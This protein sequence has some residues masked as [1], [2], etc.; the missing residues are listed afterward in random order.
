[1]ETNKLHPSFREIF[2]PRNRFALDVLNDWA[3]GFVDRDGKF[4]K[5]FQL[6]FNSSFWELY[7]FAVLKNYGCQVSLQFHRPDFVVDNPVPFC[8]EATV[9]LNDVRTKPAYEADVSDIYEDLNALN[10]EAVIRLSNRFVTKHKKYISEYSA[11]DHVSGRPFI[12]AIAPF[13]RPFF[14]MQ[15]QR[16]IETL[17]YGYYVNEEAFIKE[18]DFEKPLVSTSVEQVINH[19]GSPISLGLFNDPR[20]KEISAVIFSSTATWGKALALSDDP[21]SGSLFTALKFN[22]C[23]VRPHIEKKKKSSYFEH[24]VDG[25]RIYHNPHAVNALGPDIFRDKRVFQTYYDFDKDEWIYEQYDGQLL[26]RMVN[27]VIDNR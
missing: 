17:L 12:I 15:C 6:S 24:L 14:N 23:G 1:M 8:V 11:L 3:R 22:S 13:D 27:T 18:G 19:N 16:A 5:E 21:N 26:F 2:V 4:V 25:L 9:A 10:H 20:Y 7:L